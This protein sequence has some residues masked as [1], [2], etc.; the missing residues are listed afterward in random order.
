MAILSCYSHIYKHVSKTFGKGRYSFRK[1]MV[2]SRRQPVSKL[3]ELTWVLKQESPN[4][5][6]N[7][8]S[9]AT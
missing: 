7:A 3:M 1:P 9:I 2:H 5:S 8:H 6:R 4:P